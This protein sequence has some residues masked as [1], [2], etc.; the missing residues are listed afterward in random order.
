M[1]VNCMTPNNR[2]IYKITT[3]LKLHIVKSNENDKYVK[4]DNICIYNP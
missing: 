2:W 1:L 3:N 4:N